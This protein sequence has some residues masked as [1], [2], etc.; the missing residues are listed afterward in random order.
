[1]PQDQK[2]AEAAEQYQAL[3]R[4][5][6]NNPDTLKDWGA[7]VLRDSSR[8]QAEQGRRRGDLCKLLD[9]KPNDPVTTAQVADL[10]RQ[11][12]LVD[13]ALSLYRKACEQAPGNPQYR[14]YLG[15]YLHNLKRPTEAVAA[16]GTIAEGPNRNARTLGRLAEVL[17]GFGYLKEAVA[18]LKAAIALEPDDFDLRLKLAELS[19]RLGQFDEAESQLAAAGKLAEPDEQKA[20]DPGVAREK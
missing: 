12:E 17:A 20:S 5:D 9:K 10:L 13:E 8:P 11:A 7:L 4:A 15:E 2:Y 16:W 14:E 1:M 19:H 3:D 18:P 6:P